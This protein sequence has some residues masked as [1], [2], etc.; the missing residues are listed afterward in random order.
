MKP[1][2]AN[3]SAAIWLIFPKETIVTSVPSRLISATQADYYS[4]S[5]PLHT[6]V[7]IHEIGIVIGWLLSANLTS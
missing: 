1:S 7:L 6:F 5:L 3:S 2:F 4:P